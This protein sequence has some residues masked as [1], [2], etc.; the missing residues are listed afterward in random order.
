[1]SKEKFEL[2]F[3]AGGT[4]L[5]VLG[6]RLRREPATPRESVGAAMYTLG[7]AFEEHRDRL[8]DPDAVERQIGTIRQELCVPSP[9]RAMLAGLVEEL[10]EQVSAVQELADAAERVRG[11]IAAYLRL[12]FGGWTIS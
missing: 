12:R 2:V 10:V 9:R 4:L 8:A 6:T 7:Q 1:M 11:E 5:N 3:L